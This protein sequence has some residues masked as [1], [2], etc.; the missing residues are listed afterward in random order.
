MLNAGRAMQTNSTFTPNLPLM[1]LILLVFV[2]LVGRHLTIDP[3]WYDEHR[4]FFYAGWEDPGSIPIAQSVQRVRESDVQAPGYFV[5][6]NVWGRFIGQS[7]FAARLLSLYVGVL[8]VAVVYR[9]AADLSSWR[10]GLAAATVLATSAFFVTYAHET[11]TYAALV[12]FIALAL[13]SYWRLRNRLRWPWG[14]LLVVSMAAL[15]Y[16]HYLAAL[17]FPVVGVY[18]F[19]NF[20]RERRYFAVFG[21]MI[22]AG[23]L[24]LP[25]VAVAAQATLA[26]ATVIRSTVPTM[27]FT[28]ILT[29]TVGEFS[30]GNIALLLVLLAVGVGVRRPQSRYIAITGAAM[31]VFVYLFDQ[32]IPVLNHSRYLIV[33]WAFVAVLAGLGVERLSRIGVPALLILLVW[34][35]LGL[36]RSIHADY[37]LNINGPGAFAAWNAAA[38]ILSDSVQP[39]DLIALHL[40]YGTRYEPYHAPIADYYLGDLPVQTTGIESLPVQPDADYLREA[41]SHIEDAD[42][43][44][45][46]RD[47]GQLPDVHGLFDRAIDEQ[48]AHCAAID[49][50]NG[51]AL[52]LFIQPPN[53]GDSVMQFGDGIHMAPAL[54]FGAIKS[55]QLYVTSGWLVADDVLPHTYSVALHLTDTDGDL[56]MQADYGLPPA[57]RHCGVGHFDLTTLPAGTYTMT[58]SVYAW[59]TGERLPAQTVAG[60]QR[61]ERLPLGQITRSR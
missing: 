49:V 29:T 7:E 60:A 16:L 35:G 12:L 9:L 32:V 58:V 15:P 22:L 28:E 13:L 31:L 11:R 20:R 21:L 6:L 10:G 52:D 1:T 47:V 24:F 46:F 40:P 43:V 2:G 38:E 42:R 8:A 34:A 23:L 57:G 19:L 61:G 30:N 44:W 54:D 4:S 56:V 50:P 48:L 27:P 41:I 25:W 33:L 14:M 51:Y 53:P 55:D 26:R 39:N 3:I 5:A 37:R 45:Y 17:I 36:A 59:E 18:H